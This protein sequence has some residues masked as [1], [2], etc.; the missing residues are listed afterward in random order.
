MMITIGPHAG[1]AVGKLLL[2]VGKALG[3]AV[4]AG[5]GLELAR[6]ASGHVKKAV[7]PKDKAKDGQRRDGGSEDVDTDDERRTASAADVERIR[8]ENAALREELEALKRELRK[9]PTDVE[10]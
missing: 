4:V 5:I 2:E 6:A 10:R 1:A 7:G 8:R 9:V 3:K